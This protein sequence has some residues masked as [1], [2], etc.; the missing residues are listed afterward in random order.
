AAGVVGIAGRATERAAV[1]RGVFAHV[2]FGEDDGARLAQT[3]HYLG[4][5]RRTIVGIV[6]RRPAGGAHVE[7]VELVLDGKRNAVQWSLE[8]TGARE[9]DVELLCDLDGVGHGRVA[10]GAV[11]LRALA[12]QIDGHES[13]ELPGILDRLDVAELEARG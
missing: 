11:G 1:A 13:V 3:R 12:A 4:I 9:L 5:A 10:V 6:R 2:R 7:R 8:A